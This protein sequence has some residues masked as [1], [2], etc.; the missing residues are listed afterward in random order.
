M[1]QFVVVL[2]QVENDISGSTSSTKIIGEC[3][4]NNEL[5][6]CQIG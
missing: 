5:N 1:V 2:A 4:C 6:S 3:M